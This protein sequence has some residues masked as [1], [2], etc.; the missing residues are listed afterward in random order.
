MC[1][2]QKETAMYNDY[3]GLA[4]NPFDKQQ[5]KEQDCFISHDFKEMTSRL[6]YLKD[7]RGIVS[8]LLLLA[9]ENPIV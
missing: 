1:L 3:Y 2:I 7:T 5:I 6:E 8:S 9:W 4:F